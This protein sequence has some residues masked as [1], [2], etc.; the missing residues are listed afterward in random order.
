MDLGAPTRVTGLSK[1]MLYPLSSPASSAL[2]SVVALFLFAV[3]LN[4]SECENGFNS[5]PGL[6]FFFSPSFLSLLLL[7]LL[8]L[9]HFLLYFLLFYVFLSGWGLK[10]SISSQG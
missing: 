8:F 1:R 9:L 5:H 3:V 6:S 2:V 4:R 7:L 10:N